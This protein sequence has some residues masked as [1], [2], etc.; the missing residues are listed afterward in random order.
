[1]LDIYLWF[2]KPS[3]GARDIEG[4][5]QDKKL[6]DEIKARP[7]KLK[8][9]GFSVEN[10]TTIGAGSGGAS[11]GRCILNKFNITKF[12]DN[13]TPD[14]FAGCATG[15]HYDKAMLL[16]RKD[17]VN[18]IRF[19]FN[20]CFVTKVDWAGSEGDDA[21]GETIEFAYGALKIEYFRQTKDGK[22]ASGPPKIAIWNQV[23]NDDSETVTQY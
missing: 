9:Y 12:T 23:N 7:I 13:C 16:L 3:N 17:G 1:M 22:E 20:M 14:F 10:A 6:R 8:S 5:S 15:G 2:E 11:S 21:P 18:F 4:E 19:T